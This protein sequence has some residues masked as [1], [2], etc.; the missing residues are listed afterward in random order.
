MSPPSWRSKNKS[1]NKPLLVHILL[2]FFAWLLLRP[3]RWRKSVPPKRRLT[4]KDLQGVI[5]QEVEFFITNAVRT[6]NS[7][8]NMHI[9][10]SKGPLLKLLEEYE[11]VESQTAHTVIVC[12]KFYFSVFS[13]SAPVLTNICNIQLALSVTSDMKSIIITVTIFDTSLIGQPCWCMQYWN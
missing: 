4:L 12:C 1:R 8:C 3:W 13:L 5:S 7:T 10:L 11:A 2:R 9:S 6:S